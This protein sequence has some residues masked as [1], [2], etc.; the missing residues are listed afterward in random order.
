MMQKELNIVQSGYRHRRLRWIIVTLLLGLLVLALCVTALL[1]GNTVYSLDVVIKVLL[2]EQIQGATFA[3]ATLR[4][5]RMLAGLLVGMAFGMAGSTFQTMLRNPLASPD[6][7]GITSGASAAAVFC[8][9]VLKASG[10]IVSISAM[11]AGLGVALLIYVLSSGGNF[12]GGKLIL[13]GIGVQAMLNSF[14]SYLLLKASQ[15]DVPGAL[16]WLSGSLNGIRMSSIP[17]LALIVIFF[18]LV[19]ILL[20]RDLKILELGEQS[21]VTL[22]VRTNLTRIMLI[23]SGVFLIAFATAITG[24]VAFVA[25]LSG[26]IAAK[27]VGVGSSNELPSGLV[28]AILVLGAD[29]IGQFAFDVRFPVGIITGILGA[30]YLLYLLIRMNRTGGAA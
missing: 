19:I 6:I 9:L 2:G 22:G 5:P 24:P 15:Y 10:S 28:G 14:I 3:I 8:I 20:G 1:L 30:P 7:I 18:G 27:L 4:L 25:F 17:G 29:L 13:I 21:A 12:S 16:R 11:A 23:L 26:P